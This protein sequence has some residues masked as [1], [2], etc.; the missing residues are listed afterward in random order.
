MET[1]E[2]PV[3]VIIYLHHEVANNRWMKVI[4]FNHSM[5][6]LLVAHLLLGENA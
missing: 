2:H 4:V 5:T 3:V 1:Q 6:L